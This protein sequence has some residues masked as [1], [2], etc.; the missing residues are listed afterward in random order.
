MKEM[1]VLRLRLKPQFRTHSQAMTCLMNAQRGNKKRAEA[2]V[3]RQRIVRLRE[4][5]NE[6]RIA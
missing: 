4:K 5:F 3:L 1:K 6:S 2:K